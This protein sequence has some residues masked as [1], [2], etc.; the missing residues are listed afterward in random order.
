MLLLKMS[1][2]ANTI[3]MKHLISVLFCVIIITA[4]NPAVVGK[5]GL[6]ETQT[7]NTS[8]PTIE[9]TPTSSLVEGKIELTE[10]TGTRWILQHME[11]HEPIAN[12]LITLQISPKRFSGSAG[13]N[14]Y[15]AEYTA[16]SQ[17]SYS[18]EF[19]AINVEGC[20]E[21]EGVLD[22]EKLYMDL[23][24]SSSKYHLEDTELFLVDEQGKVLLHYHLR[25]EF[26]VTPDN[27][28]GK[29]W[30]LISA[31]GL[32]KDNLSAFTLRFDESTFSGTTACREYSGKFQAVADSLQFTYMSM[33]TD[34]DCDEKDGHAE[35]GYTTLLQ[36]V[37][38]YNVSFERL[39]LFTRRGKKLVFEL[40]TEGR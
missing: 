28:I 1:C 11:G 19:S 31:T 35:G 21:P 37:E 34:Y 9:I 26:D 3:N 15:Y 25:Q 27:L 40:V 24:R 38:Q 14:A 20:K 22:Q 23:L 6:A 7:E 10:L 2:A 32:D 18:I 16:E 5:S 4:C 33:T 13:C 12:T 17:N 29:T 39:E 30:Q 36:N 8:T